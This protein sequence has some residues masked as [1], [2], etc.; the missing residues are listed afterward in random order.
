MEQ[1]QKLKKATSVENKPAETKLDA[2]RYK[3]SPWSDDEIKLLIKAVNLY[4]GG[5]LERWTKIA[6]FLRQ[7]TEEELPRNQSDIIKMSKEV[8]GT[9]FL[10]QKASS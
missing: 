4:P 6:D 8:R 1:T 9:K 2:P 5:T 10:A 3:T 7:H